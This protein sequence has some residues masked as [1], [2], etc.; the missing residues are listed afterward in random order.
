MCIME[1]KNAHFLTTVA[2]SHQLLTN[3]KNEFA[4]VGRSNVG[5]SSLINALTNNSK[6]AKTSSVPGKTKFVNYFV[7]NDGDFHIVDLPG[8][9]YHNASKQDEQKWITLIEDYFIQ[10]TNLSCV[11]VLV[12]IRHDVSPLDLMMIKFLVYYRLNFVVILTKADK[13]SKAEQARQVEK[14]ASQIA[15]PKSNL[16]V[17][18]AEKKQ[19]LDKVLEKIGNYCN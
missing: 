18:S 13:L 3:T 2:M 15:I 1:I 14:I 8:Y 12:D 9:G 17:I 5:K 6:L 11:F 16:I 10:S 4:F 7:V 19:G